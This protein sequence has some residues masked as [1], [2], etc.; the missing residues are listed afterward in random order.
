V[1]KDEGDLMKPLAPLSAHDDRRR[2]G[3]WLGQAFGH[4]IVVLLPVSV[5]GQ[6]LARSEQGVGQHVAAQKQAG[7]PQQQAGAPKLDVQQSTGPVRRLSV[8]EAVKLALEHNLGLQI[9]RINPEIQDV[10]VAQA[11]SFWAP[12]LGSTVSRSTQSQAPTDLLSGTNTVQDGSFF[13][14]LS[15]N[16]VLPFGGNYVVTWG[17]SRITTTSP[18]Q[19]YSPKLGSQLQ[20]QVTQPLLRNL[21]I[22]NVRQTLVLSQKTRDASDIQLHARM[23]QA[24]QAA[25]NAYWDLVYQIDNLKAA[26]QSLEL[27]QRSLKDNTRRVEIGTMAPIDIVDAK[28]EVARNEEAVIVAQAQIEQAQD[29]LRTL[30]FDPSTPDFWAMKVEPSDTVPFQAQTIDT[31]AAVRSALSKRTDLEIAR[32]SIEQSDVSLRFFRNQL[33]P[34]VSAQVRYTAVGIGGVQLN[35]FNPSDIA[36]GSLPP[37]TIVAERSFGSVLSQVF[38]N[39]YPQW[40]YSVNIGYP[41]GT[42]TAK[43]NLERAKLQYQQAQTQLKNLEMQIVAQVRNAARQVQANQKRVESATASRELAE[44]KL[45]AEEKKFAAGIRE[46]FFVFQAQRDLSTARVAEVRAIA[47]YNKSLVDFEAVQEVAVGGSTSGVISAG[48]GAIQPGSSAGAI[49]R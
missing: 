3:H 24:T 33:L 40:T 25:K 2:L 36:S 23:V 9:E 13:S 28:V 18:L 8:D 30:I 44:E 42:S 26:Q 31:E 38:Q 15:V 22:D 46:T 48:A 20:M 17:G 49:I 7:E 35:S 4:A 32:N 19:T 45:A 12:S 27:A 29:A 11:R 10:S 16:Q 39:A 14:G 41:L 6:T 37:R 47:D 43:A 5:F 21:T 34:D 1:L